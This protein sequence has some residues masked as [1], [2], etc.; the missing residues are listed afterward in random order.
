MS[1]PEVTQSN[2]ILQGRR[3]HEM[4]SN[5]GSEHRKTQNNTYLMLRLE[6]EDAIGIAKEERWKLQNSF[7]MFRDMK[8]LCGE[9]F[10][11][12]IFVDLFVVDVEPDL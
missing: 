3:R 9:H 4:E 2:A 8:R 5:I 11:T 6:H 12:L 1:N 7:F 10:E